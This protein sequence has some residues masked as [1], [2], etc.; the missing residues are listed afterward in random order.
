M[1]SEK[2]EESI[3]KFWLELG[4]VSRSEVSMEVP[5]EEGGLLNGSQ[6]VTCV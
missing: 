2:T 3:R 5:R 6:E 1:G 4:L